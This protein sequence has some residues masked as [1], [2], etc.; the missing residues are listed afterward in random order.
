MNTKASSKDFFSIIQSRLDGRVC[1]DIGI[2]IILGIF[3]A[4]SAGA[5]GQ[6]ALREIQ[7][8]HETGF[9]LATFSKGLAIFAVSLYSLTIAC[10]YVVRSRPTNK[11]AGWWPCLAALLGGFM[12]M[13][14]LFFKPSTE[15]PII[16]QILASLLVLLGNGL[17]AYILTCLGRSFSILPESRKLVVS[18]PYKRIRHPLYLVE[19]LATVGALINFWSIGAILLVSVQ[20]IFQF[21]RMHYEEKVLSAQFP[22]YQEYAQRTFRLIPGIY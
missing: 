5:Y 9:N 8:L 4:F 10:L 18:G 15:L 6:N 13:G 2:R 12:G 22:E 16:L 7:Q 17:T 21:V 14:L 20:F 11:F 3:F 1:V 19:A